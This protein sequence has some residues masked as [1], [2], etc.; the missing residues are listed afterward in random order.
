MSTGISPEKELLDRS[1]NCRLE[2]CDSSG[3]RT[4]LKLLDGRLRT[5]RRG[6][7]VPNQEGISPKNRLFPRSRLMSVLQVSITDGKNPRK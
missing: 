1:N 6:T 7:L 5:L 4:P 3:G 2:S